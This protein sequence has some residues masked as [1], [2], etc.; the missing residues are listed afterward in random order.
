[1]IRATQ[2]TA[3]RRTGQDLR[4]SVLRPAAYVR[5]GHRVAHALD[6]PGHSGG[7]TDGRVPPEPDCVHP[8]HSG[9]EGRQRSLE[10]LLSG[11]PSITLE[12][13]GRGM[14]D[15]VLDLA[16]L[17]PPAQLVDK[18]VYSPWMTRTLQILRQKH[19]VDTRHRRRDRPLCP[20]N[21]ARRGATASWWRPMPFAVQLTRRTMHRCVSIRDVWT[22]G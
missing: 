12:R 2:A 9:R 10:A 18:H 8:V 4:S 17:V 14:V 21:R 1:M 5:R 6:A 22:T 13:L 19:G 16:R 7:A 15:L 11:W 3:E 20:G